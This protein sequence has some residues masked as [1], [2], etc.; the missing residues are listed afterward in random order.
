MYLSNIPNDYPIYIT[1]F[2]Y[3]GITFHFLWMIH[4]Y[5]SHPSGM[6]RNK[7]LDKLIDCLFMDN[8]YGNLIKGEIS[9]TMS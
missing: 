4:Y 9:S 2:V 1:H 7:T 8:K 5:L 6:K 3:K